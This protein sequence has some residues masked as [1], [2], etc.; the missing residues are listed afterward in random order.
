MPDKGFI[1]ES[2]SPAAAPLMLAAKSGGGVR[3]CHDYRGLN[4]IT[5]KNRYPLPLIRETLDNLCGAKYY[6]KLH[7]TA[8]NRIRVTEDTNG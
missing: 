3:I 4:A 7:V 2:S 5:V 8:F 1:R 6:T